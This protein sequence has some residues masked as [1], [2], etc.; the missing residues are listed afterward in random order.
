MTVQLSY[1]EYTFSING[2]IVEIFEHFLIRISDHLFGLS[3][4]SWVELQISYS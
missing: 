2:L 3:T 1:K 4:P